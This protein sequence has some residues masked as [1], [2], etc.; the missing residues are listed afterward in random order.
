MATFP[1]MGTITYEEWVRMAETNAH[2]EV[3]NGEIRVTPSNK[4]PHPTV[5][6]NL[7]AAF[8][9]QLDRSATRLFGSVFSLVVRRESLTIRAPDIAVFDRSTMVEQDGYVHSAPLLAIEVLSPSETR[10]EI[11]EKLH[12]DESIGIA[13]VWLVSP[14]VGHV[15]VLILEEGKL[16]RSAILAEGLLKPKYFPTVQIDIA[17]IWPA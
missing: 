1:K 15:E 3:V 12:D 9:R 10:K 16:C 2:E 8:H 11:F 6:G 5:V 4:I 7:T 13:E 14:Q 17:E